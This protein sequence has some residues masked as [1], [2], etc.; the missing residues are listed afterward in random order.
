MC[1]PD[2]ERGAVG[3]Q[4]GSFGR[5]HRLMEAPR[6]KKINGSAGYRSGGDRR[7]EHDLHIFKKSDPGR[8]SQ[9]DIGRISDDKRHAPG[10]SGNK[11]GRE[12]GDRVDPGGGA[13]I[14]DERRKRQNDDII[15]SKDR[16]HRNGQIEQ[17]EEFSPAVSRIP[18]HPGG[19]IPEK[20]HFVEIN[21]EQGHADKQ[22]ENFERIDRA[23]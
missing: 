7:Q 10:I 16:Q 11:F 19:Q 1:H 14:A 3:A 22:H 9:I 17:P 4:K 6:K 2:D 20:S 13:E 23:V 15:G 12:V 18:E 8:R 5:F 21:R